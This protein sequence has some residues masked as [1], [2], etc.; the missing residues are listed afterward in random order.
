MNLPESNV[1][2]WCIRK[3]TE[4]FVKLTEEDGVDEAVALD[5]TWDCYEK[6]I[7]NSDEHCFDPRDR[8]FEADLRTIVQKGYA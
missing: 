2:L 6:A 8:L 1:V 3:C 7:T 4:R 5:R